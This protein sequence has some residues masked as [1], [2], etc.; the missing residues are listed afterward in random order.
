MRVSAIERKDLDDAVE[1]SAVIDGF[2]LWYRFPAGYPVS[3]RGDAFLA[4]ALQPA[5]R[6]GETLV[7][8]G[9]PVSPRL[10]A[11]ID[12]F[13]DIHHCWDPAFRKIAIEA[14]VEPDRDAIPEVGSFFS[15]GVDGCYTFLK[16][17]DE[18]KHLVFIKGV[19]IQ[20][21]NDSL[22]G[23]ALTVNRRFAAAYG[24]SLLSVETNIRNFCHPRG[25]VWTIYTGAGLASVGLALRLARFYIASSHTYAEL[26][27]LGS[28]PLTDHLWSTEATEF[29][30]DGA[31]ARR[32][33]KLRR[34]AESAPALKGLRVCWQDAG[35][36]CGRCEKCLRT[37]IA[38]HLLGRSTPALPPLD[39][40]D[41]VRGMR[42]ESDDE[43]P[44]FEDNYRLAKE[45]GNRELAAVLGRQVRNYRV[46]RLI[47][48]LDR[49]LTGGRLKRGFRKLAP[50]RS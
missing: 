15:G 4:A 17:A 9:A 5:M 35:F 49:E 13:Q 28:H 1:L 40:L 41:G 26:H 31:E 47:V 37:M 43:L 32:C 36:N 19:D 8:D 23:E 10:L 39:S 45:V 11:G 22:F 2:R 27:P 18:I 3:L 6:A 20:V 33:D 30:H 50:L 38:L 24:K 16:H 14:D 25:T 12:R 44:H 46:R 48:D 7:I 42:I 29:I 34:L 21:D